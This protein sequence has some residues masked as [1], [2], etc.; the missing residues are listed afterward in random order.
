MVIM[1]QGHDVTAA[2]SERIDHFKH[3]GNYVSLEQN[4]TQNVGQMS[5]LFRRQQRIE[6]KVCVLV[7][8]SLHQAVVN[9]SY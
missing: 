2:K 7:Y 4:K 1:C 8:K 3:G 6:Y 5:R 9:C